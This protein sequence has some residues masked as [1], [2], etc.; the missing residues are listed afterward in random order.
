[1]PIG[2]VPRH[3]P[4]MLGFLIAIGPVSVDM[5]LPAFPTIAHNFHDKAAPALTLAAYFVGLAF[6]QM[7]QGPLS[8]RIGRRVPILF[9][10]VLYTLASFGC[11]AAWDT[12]S[13][14]LFRVLAAFGGSAS[15]VIPRA[16]VRDVSDGAA[17]ALLYSKLMLVMGVAPIIAPILGSGVVLVASWRVIFLVAAAYGI[18]ALWLVW[19]HLPDT[20]PPSRRSLIGVRSIIV[21]YGE[22]C[23]ERGFITH[24]VVG[25]FTV[26]AMFAYI[27]GTPAVFINHYHW[28]PTGYAAMFATNAAAYIAFNQLNPRL[29]ARF[30]IRPVITVAVYSL[31]ATTSALMVF[32]ILPLGALPIMAALFASEFGFGLIMPS[33]MV[34]ALSRHQSHAGSASALMGTI[35][36]CGGAIAGALV[37]LY[38]NGTAGPMAVTMLACAAL[39]ALVAAFRPKMTI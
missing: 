1:M 30:G 12:V 16:M 22:I 14:S 13:L 37:G 23:V 9:G 31:L 35:Q 6:G 11:A 24:A 32:S 2:T 5:Y 20:L 39:A 26:S 17:A 18:V 36:Y 8:D 29:V 15:V 25:T 19:R 3:L 21:R 4:L 10:L 28:S 33:S 7:M 34:G 38:A 27:A